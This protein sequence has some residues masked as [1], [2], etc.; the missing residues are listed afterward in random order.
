MLTQAYMQNAF[1]VGGLV[2]I[3]SG[4][5]GFFVVL[6]AASFAAHALA[7]VGFAGAAGA[8][9]IGVDPLW[10]LLAF[11]LL[12][13]AGIGVLGERDSGRDASTALVMT[14][15][16]GT[17][18]LFLVLNR[19]YA[20]EAFSLLFGTIVGISRAEVVEMAILV[21]VA[22]ALIALLYRPLLFATVNP[23]AARARGIPMRRLNVAFLACLAI[24]AAAT[25][26]TVGTLLIFAL[27]VAPPA[28]A[29]AL[30]DRPSAALV[31]AVV[32]NLACCWTGIALAYYLALP[33]G[34]LIAV[35]AALVYLAART[36][37]GYRDRRGSKGARA[38]GR[39]VPLPS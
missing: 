15:A 2:A 39:T 33:I 3:V 7:Q 6:R 10:G 31:L 21:T 29:V 26:P 18:A 4:V 17:G 27:L 11:A 13:A 24:A 12:G 8:V 1:A 36:V 25:V 37:R 20:T 23:D 34:F 30:T 14:A 35:L 22:L 32:L 5:V 19:S 28:A 16:L 9:L 38:G